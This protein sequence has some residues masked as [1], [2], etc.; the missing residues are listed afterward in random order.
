MTPPATS[1]PEPSSFPGLVLGGRYRLERIIGVGGM[2]TVWEAT[3]LEL[4]RRV[5]V[6]IR[7]RHLDGVPE[8]VERFRREA[9]LGAGLA[10]QNIVGVL[11]SIDDGSHAA[12]VMELVRGRSLRQHLDDDGALRIDL[13]AAIAVQILEALRYIHL[14]GLVHRDLKPANILLTSDRRAL[15]AD[16]GIASP[17][18]IVDP[19]RSDAFVGTAR[20]LAPEQVVGGIVDGRADLYALG[21]V[22][23]ECVTGTA[24]FT[25]GDDLTIARARLD[26]RP[27]PIRRVRPESPE[28]LE[29]FISALLTREPD[30]RPVDPARYR[31]LL[32][33]LVPGA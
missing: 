31:R 12:F 7:H 4:T 25:G 18:G 17:V 30:G 8:I 5:A 13:V 27:P 16:F 3:D 19:I 24:P 23:H 11:D 15:L 33:D 21:A 22:L 29:R 2:A 32:L 6:K 9:R 28:T 14:S 10:H 1:G 26:H 20:Y